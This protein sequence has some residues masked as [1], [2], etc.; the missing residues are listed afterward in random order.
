MGIGQGQC[1]AGRDGFCHRRRP[2]VQLDEKALR[3]EGH[4][5]HGLSPS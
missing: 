5:G 3:I 2:T 1:L 4:V